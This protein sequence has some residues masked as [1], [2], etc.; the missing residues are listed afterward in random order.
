[1]I[2]ND[3]TNTLSSW[4]NTSP[5]CQWAGVRCDRRDRVSTLDLHG[6]ELTGSISPHITNLSSQVSLPAGQPLHRSDPGPNRLSNSVAGVE[7]ELEPPPRDDTDNTM[8]ALEAPGAESSSK[9]AHRTDPDVHRKLVISKHTE[10]RYNTLS[11]P[12]PR[13]L[14]HLKALEQLQLSINNL[15]GTVPSSLYNVSSLV[16]FALASNDLYGEVPSDIG[17]WLPKLLVF[18]NCFNQ[19]TG[20][21]PP[22]LHNRTKIQSIRMSHNHLVGSVPPD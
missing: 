2:T 17:F 22:S 10:S 16:L 14:G 18:H 5:I 1:M 3:P 21:I 4:N 9:P 7:L 11:G 6:L 20:T 8:D 13:E 19:F 15:T 12:I